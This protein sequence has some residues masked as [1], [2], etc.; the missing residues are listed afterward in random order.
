[1]SRRQALIGAAAAA[2]AGS[3]SAFVPKVLADPLGLPIGCQTYTVRTLIAQD[4]PGTMKTLG[5]AG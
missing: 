2:G 3:L 1:M 4:F 5:D